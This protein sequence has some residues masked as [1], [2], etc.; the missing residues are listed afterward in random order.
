MIVR[1]KKSKTQEREFNITHPIRFIT[2]I[3]IITTIFAI[4]VFL[5]YSSQFNGEFSKNQEIWGAFGDYVGGVLNPIFGYSALIV[6]LIT[7]ILQNNSLKIA[8][9][10]LKNSE[11]ELEL[12]RNELEN[13]I[14]VLKQQ[15]ENTRIQ[16]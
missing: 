10:Q 11:K 6:L 15:N 16:K 5:F 13:S 4:S 14:N 2:L 8:S 9:K 7:L 3:L 1:N 12:T